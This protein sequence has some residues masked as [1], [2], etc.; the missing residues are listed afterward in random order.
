MKYNLFYE[1]GKIK[2]KLLFPLDIDEIHKNSLVDNE[3]GLSMLVKY[4]DEITEI[5]KI[6][7]SY[8]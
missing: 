1:T 8:Y 5:L 3:M 2:Q 6:S 7:K 4:I